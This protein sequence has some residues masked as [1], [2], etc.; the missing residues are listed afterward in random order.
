MKNQTTSFNYRSIY[1]FIAL[2]FIGLVISTGAYSQVT[3][4]AAPTNVKVSVSSSSATSI[5]V[6]FNRPTYTG[7]GNITYSITISPSAG[8]STNLVQAQSISTGSITVLGL[9]ADIYYTFT[10]SAVGGA[11]ST[12][13]STASSSITPRAVKT[14]YFHGTTNTDWN[15][16]S[17]WSTSSSTASQNPAVPIVSDIAVINAN[18]IVVI[19]TSVATTAV[20]QKLTLSSGGSLTNSS[21]SSLTVSPTDVSGV[22]LTL[23]GGALNNEGMLT[24]TN[25]NQTTPYYNSIACNGTNTLTF[26]GTN[27]LAVYPAGTSNALFVGGSN[28]ATTIAGAG[29]TVGSAGSGTGVGFSVFSLS[30]V[31]ATVTINSGTTLNMYVGATGI[32]GN[33]FYFASSSSVINNGTLNVTGTTT[34][35][36]SAAISAYEQTANINTYFKNTGSFTVTGFNQPF[37]FG[38][39]TNSTGYNKF[40]NT[41]ITNITTNSGGAYGLNSSNI[42]PNQYINS[43]TLTINAPTNAIKINASGDSF[44][45]TGTITIT[46]GNIY[47]AA[48]AGSYPTIN[49]NSGGV[50]NFNYG[51]SAGTT[52][53][54]SG[55]ILSNNS[56]ATINGSCTFAA[57]TLVTKAGCTLSP[58]DYNTGTSTSG[59]GRMILTPSATGTKFPLLG[60]L[61]IQINGTTTPSTDYDQLQCTEIDVT[62]DT[63]SAAINYT[64]SVYDYIGVVSATTAKIGPFKSSELPNGWVVDNTSS[65]YIGIKYG[66]SVND[67]NAGDGSLTDTNIQYIGRWD[68]SDAQ[69]YKSYWGGAYLRVKFTGTSISI[70]LAS[71]AALLVMIDGETPRAVSA[72]AGVTQLNITTLSSGVHTLIVGSSSQNTEVSFMGLI[73]NPGAVTY[74]DVSK[75]MIDYIGDSITAGTG[76]TGTSIVNYAWSTAELLGCDH[77]QIAFSGLSLSTGYG[78]LTNKVGLDSLYFLFKNYNHLSETPLKVWDYSYTPNV[79]YMALGTNDVCGSEPVTTFSNHASAFLQRLRAHY[80][81]ATLVVQRPLNGSF[82]TQLSQAV[83]AMNNSGDSKVYYINTQGWLDAA[84]FSDGTHPNAQGTVKYINNLYP[85]LQPI[86]NGITTVTNTKITTSFNISPNPIID[87][88]QIKADKPIKKI[89]LYNLCGEILESFN[90][91]QS[92]VAVNLNNINSGIYLVKITYEDGLFNIQKVIKK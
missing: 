9:T 52:Q 1:K 36:S 87:I 84:D 88:M 19:G 47:S 27:N 67:P 5:V 18:K 90:C 59:I 43:G 49:N 6:S 56:G 65:T 37:S 55:V 48:A 13:T 70:K 60:T 17:N 54:T 82:A 3:V 86:I 53:A 79:V 35:T 30:A 68:K 83:T 28:S 51:A 40:E 23:S 22:A 91:N 38:G 63:L 14:L 85:I 2:L 7:T 31:G 92:A 12:W 16:A 80:P 32:N 61:K 34:S 50:F 24:V 11:G 25:V 26:N 4:T 39:T 78:C 33:G 20:C 64:P 57:N 58:G 29:F 69:V 74:R 45:N 21:G 42:L 46:K 62:A 10:V 72:I 44:T 66:Q 76:P 77:A 15:T 75:L 81:F 8:T 71:S 73:I 41:G 89:V